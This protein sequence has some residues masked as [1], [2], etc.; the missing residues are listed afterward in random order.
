LFNVVWKVLIAL[1]LL[2]VLERLFLSSSL[3]NLILRAAAYGALCGLRVACWE[4]TL[5]E[6]DGAHSS[7]L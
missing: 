4:L 3:S 7:E 6:R 2:G 5:S 1:K